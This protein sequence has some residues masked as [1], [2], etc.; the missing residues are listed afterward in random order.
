MCVRYRSTL[1]AGS[2]LGCTTVKWKTGTTWTVYRMET[3][4]HVC[5]KVK[6]TKCAATVDLLHSNVLTWVATHCT[7]FALSNVPK[8]T[9]K[10]LWNFVFRAF[11]DNILSRTTVSLC[12]CVWKWVY[13]CIIMCECEQVCENICTFRCV[14]IWVWSCVQNRCVY[15]VCLRCQISQIC[16]DFIQF[17][18]KMLKL[19]FYL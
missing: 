16:H 7:A 17:K 3:I 6:S 13:R 10:L 15:K 8:C 14:C 11:Y 18:C 5:L 4:R 9:S 1:P 2:W 12:V 19:F